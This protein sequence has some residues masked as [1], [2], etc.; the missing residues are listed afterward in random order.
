M[1]GIKAAIICA[2]CQV[3]CA[4]L[5]FRLKKQKRVVH[6]LLLTAVGLLPVYTLF[7]IWFGNGNGTFAEFVNGI[8]VYGGLFYCFSHPITVLNTSLTMSIMMLCQKASQQ[9][10]S[11]QE[12]KEQYP[13][14]RILLKRIRRM[15]TSGHIFSQSGFY[16]TTH[17]GK[18][19]ATAATALKKFMKCYPGN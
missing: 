1:T 17:K 10:L 6:S 3:A 5:L 9:S 8:L 18:L 16:S 13:Y 7:F 12:L 15:E 14:D 2:I 19:Y 4:A 11:F